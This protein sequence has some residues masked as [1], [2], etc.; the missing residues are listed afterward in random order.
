MRALVAAVVVAAALAV[1]AAA[2]A[3]D[4]TITAS[5]GAKLACTLNE[6]AGSP[7]TAGWPAV[8]L[9]H[10]LGG[11]RQDLVGLPRLVEVAFED[12]GPAQQDLTLG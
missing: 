2:S 5:D 8:M 1:P 6:P 11:K 4:L 7:P 3:E 12:V 9:F 10:G